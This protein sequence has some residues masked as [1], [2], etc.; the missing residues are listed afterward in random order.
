[1]ESSLTGAGARRV[2]NRRRGSEG[3]DL[4]VFADGRRDRRAR[5]ELGAAVDAIDFEQGFVGSTPR[6]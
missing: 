1:M 2:E 4:G 3:P 6:S 5:G